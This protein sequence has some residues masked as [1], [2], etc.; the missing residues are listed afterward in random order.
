[1]RFRGDAAAKSQPGRRWARPSRSYAQ[2]RAST[3][4]LGRLLGALGSN[5]GVGHCEEPE[6][7]TSPADKRERDDLLM[8]S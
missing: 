4:L 2:L 3:H 5:V 1:M 8:K 6:S 7:M